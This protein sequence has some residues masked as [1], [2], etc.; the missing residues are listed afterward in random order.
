MY[1]H[2][3]ED[4]F[5]REE[6]PSILARLETERDL[7]GIILELTEHH[8]IDDLKGLRRVLDSF[9]SRGALVAIDD[10]GSGYAGL[11]QIIELSNRPP[12]APSPCSTPASPRPEVEGT[13]CTGRS[14]EL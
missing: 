14:G 2:D 4:V 13:S 10:A 8:S 5:L 3:D 7:G 11:K 1:L 6:A 9:R 12:T